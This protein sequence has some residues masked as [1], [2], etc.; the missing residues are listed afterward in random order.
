MTVLKCTVLRITGRIPQCP[1]VVW[2]TYTDEGASVGC[3]DLPNAL[4]ITVS[5]VVAR[6]EYV[7]PGAE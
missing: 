3:C 7:S 5:I 2:N 6:L 4:G 1:P